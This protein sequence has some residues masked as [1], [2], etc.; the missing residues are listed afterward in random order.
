MGLIPME[1]F[2]AQ[3]K[4]SGTFHE[5]RKYLTPIT[6]KGDKILAHVGACKQSGC[7]WSSQYSNWAGLAAGIWQ[8]RQEHILEYRVRKL[9]RL[10]KSN[11][12]Q[13]HIALR[14]CADNNTHTEEGWTMAVTRTMRELEPR[15]TFQASDFKPQLLTYY[16]MGMM[17][18]QAA[19]RIYDLH[20]AV[21]RAV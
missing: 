3:M 1:N 12:E 15:G 7:R 9:H 5:V 8:H 6:Y 21:A 4:I 19:Q 11:K 20:F 13:I 17:A 16:T 14:L 18:V 2:T 10:L